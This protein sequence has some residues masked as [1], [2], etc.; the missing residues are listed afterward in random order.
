MAART[1]KRIVWIFFLLGF[2]QLISGIRYSLNEDEQ[3]KQAQIFYEE[4]D[5]GAAYKLYSTLLANYPKDAK[6][7]YRVG[8]CILFVGD[9]KGDRKKAIPYLEFAKKKIAELDKEVVFYLG[10]AYHLNYRFDE[11]LRNYSEYKEIASSSN[12][13]KLKVD[14]EMESAKNGKRLLSRVK[15]LVVIEKK[16]MPSADY[17]RSYPQNFYGGN[18]LVKTDDFKLGADKKKKDKL[19]MFQSKDRSVILFASYGDNGDRGKDIYMARRLPNGNFAKAFPI[20]GEVN[21]DLDEDYPYLHPNGKD[22]FFCSKGHNS[23]GGFD[24]FKSTW[25]DENQ[26]W[27]KPVNLDFPINTPAD[28][29]QF[30][31]DSLEKL[32]IF[33]SNRLSEFG[34][35]DVYKIDIERRPTEFGFISGSAISKTDGL[36]LK[37]QIAVK[38]IETGENV[39]TFTVNE[40]GGYN[41]KL[42]N[43]GGKFIFTVS[44]PNYPTQSEGI[45][46]P[47]AFEIRPF[48]QFITYEDQKLV[49]Q[50]FFEEKEDEKDYENLMAVIEEKQQLNE[51]STQFKNEPQLIAKKDIPLTDSVPKKNQ[52]DNP[53]KNLSNAQLLDTAKKDLADLK[54]E[55]DDLNKQADNAGLMAANLKKI[56]DEKQTEADGNLKKA[57]GITD[58]IQKKEA[59]DNAKDDKKKADELTELSG[60]ADGIA[61][62]IKEDAKNKQKEAEL[63]DQFVK[64]M[65]ELNKNPKSK[66]A[67]DNRE[68]I[69]K[70]LIT[71]QQKTKD[72]K[73]DNV[74]TTTEAE[75]EKKETELADLNK[76]NDEIKKDVAVI[77]SEIKQKEEELKNTKD[78]PTKETLIAEIQNLKDEKKGKEDKLATSENNIKNTQKEIDDKKH[79]TEIATT[80]IENSKKGNTDITPLV[81]KTNAN[82][83]KTNTDVVI[84]KT[85]DTSGTTSVKTDVY[86]TQENDIKEKLAGIEGTEKTKETIGTKI[87]VLK[88]WTTKIDERIK[89]KKDSLNKTKDPAD[90]KRLNE[91]IT[92]LQNQ[93]KENL[94]QVAIAQK[95]QKTAPTNDELVASKNKNPVLPSDSN[96]NVSVAKDPYFEKQDGFKEQLTQIAAKDITK[97]NLDD[98]KGVLKTWNGTID[99]KI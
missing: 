93:K 51:N 21:T 15:E 55:A 65:V 44:T 96:G 37:S 28:D 17:F 39:G 27:G 20:P 49:I 38:S 75:I 87:E 84:V 58:P 86:K 5:Y 85:T 9:E 6:Y 97:E 19:I 64:T 72:L 1:K 22:L 16:R 60:K 83:E 34:R 99:E 95:E 56:A 70:E 52:P 7:Q 98:R 12:A 53:F 54:K 67:L 41:V 74:N 47:V 71:H 11:A 57:E 50:N 14:R 68:K 13:K 43:T 62:D 94:N 66:T 82:T 89:I 78:K 36:P 18:L 79:E 3:K 30:V 73:H 76:K 40:K 25:N 59:I 81:A 8:V 26:T 24:I 88:D 90:K 63:Q 61:K 33:S 69:Q 46:L 42:P 35:I 92:N 48:K 10:K 32:A 91:Q 77:D 2:F 23:M 45:S 4:E 80:F 29:I 31:T